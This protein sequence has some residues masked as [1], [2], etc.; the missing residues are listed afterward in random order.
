MR[1]GCESGCL[2]DSGATEHMCPDQSRFENYRKLDVPVR[3]WTSAGENMC[4]TG[5]G[6]IPVLACDGVSRTRRVLRGTLH[7][8]EIKYN[9]FS[10]VQTMSTGVVMRSEGTQIK[11]L[12]GEETVAVADRV[13]KL[14]KMDFVYPS[15][16]LVCNSKGLSLYD[17]HCR[18]GHLC[19]RQVESIL[20]KC[21][22]NYDAERFQCESC[23][24]GKSDSLPFPKREHKATAIGQ[25][26]HA[27]VC[28]PMDVESLGGARY[29]LLI[30]DEYSHFRSI[31]F[32]KKKDEACD[33]IKQFIRTTERQHGT[34]VKMFRSDNG[35]EFVNGKLK[36]YFGEKGIIHQTTIPRTPQQ[37]GCVERE[38]R[39]VMNIERTMRE[40]SGLGKELWAES[41]NTAVYKLTRKR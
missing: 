16:S 37:N 25:I 33:L 14:F 6:D 30:K 12:R 20:K 8:P 10:L 15:L 5:V 7:V 27:D 2:M 41:A 19:V 9:L 36:N 26:V 39:T 31:F 11:F 28:G 17:W 3:V 21:T 35:G 38:M 13:G 34:E 1:G 22:I 40:A 32:M 29:H 24:S 18:M 4:A 23:I